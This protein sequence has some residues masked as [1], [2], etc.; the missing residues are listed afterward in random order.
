M[1][2]DIHHHCLHE[3]DSRSVATPVP[4]VRLQREVVHPE[5]IQLSQ[6]R[7]LCRLQ[8]VL[9]GVVVVVAAVG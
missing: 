7:F 3:S 1:G 6:L 5:R 2:E 4:A 8:G 9:P